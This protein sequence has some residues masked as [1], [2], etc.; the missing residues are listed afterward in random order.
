MGAKKASGQQSDRRL[1][2]LPAHRPDCAE[3]IFA[4][5]LTY[6]KK[7]VNY[8]VKKCTNSP[9]QATGLDDWIS[10]PLSGVGDCE[11]MH[12]TRQ[13]LERTLEPRHRIIPIGMSG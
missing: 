9:K 11:I 2:A 7:R 13:T 12:K 6:G 1:D 4:R 5:V 10:R 3:K 8:I